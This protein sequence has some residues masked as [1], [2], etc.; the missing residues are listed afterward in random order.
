MD[1]ISVGTLN[2]LE[3]VRFLGSG[4]RVYSASSS[5]CF[6]DTGAE[7]ATEQTPFRPRSP[8]AVAK[9][10]AHWARS[11]IAMPTACLLPT[12]S[13]STMNLRSGPNALSPKRSF[14]LPAASE[15]AIV[16]ALSSATSQFD[17]IGDGRRNM[18]RRCVP[19]V[20]RMM[21][22]A[23]LNDVGCTLPSG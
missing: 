9:A 19:D 13:C 6:G 16:P 21:V 14:A 22:H 4:I 2:L 8:Y 1:S 11:T 5:E 15:R 23:E 17:G 18:S 20:V 10:A 12:G 3:V 7:T